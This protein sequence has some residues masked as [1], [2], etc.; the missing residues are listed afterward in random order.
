MKMLIAGVFIGVVL[1]WGASWYLLYPG[2]PAPTDRGQFGDMFGAVNSLFS[3]LA[4]AGVLIA[5]YMQNLELGLQRKELKLARE[6]QQKSEQALRE[7]VEQ[8]RKTA[9]LQ[10]QAAVL[11]NIERHLVEG[12]PSPFMRQHLDKAFEVIM[13][14]FVKSLPPEARKA[15]ELPK[16]RK[17]PHNATA[18]ASPP[19]SQP[20]G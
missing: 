7:Q 4:F 12:N 19:P 15:I 11:K 16:E 8:M 6:A 9:G 10:A 13:N 14:E 20:S 17:A 18:Q 5:I 1:I 2:V 3:G